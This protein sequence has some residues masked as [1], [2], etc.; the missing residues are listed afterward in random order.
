MARKTVSIENIHNIIVAWSYYKYWH[1]FGVDRTK[2]GDCVKLLSNL[3][4]KFSLIRG[5]LH[6][7]YNIVNN[8]IVK[9]KYYNFIAQIRT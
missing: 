6:I 1:K 5:R 3:K 7:D 4:I 9:L 8:I 2:S